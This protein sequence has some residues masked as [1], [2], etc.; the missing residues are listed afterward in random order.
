MQ[1]N[2]K[3]KREHEDETE[4]LFAIITNL[5]ELNQENYD[6]IDKM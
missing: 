5:E 4:R 3:L 1:L 2:E 6:R